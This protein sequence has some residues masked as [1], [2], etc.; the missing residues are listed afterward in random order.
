L[1]CSICGREGDKEY[2]EK[3][4]LGPAQKKKE[5]ETIDVC[6]QCGDQIHLLFDNYTLKYEMNSLEALRNNDGVKK[7]VNWIRKQPL[8][9][10]IS[11]KKKKRRK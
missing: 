5:S 1:K 7:Y 10:H 3:H 4:H 9:K 2:F 6:H 8:S 11:T